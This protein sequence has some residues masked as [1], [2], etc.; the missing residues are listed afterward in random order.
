MAPD[1]GSADAMPIP[2][3]CYPAS[4]R[5]PALNTFPGSS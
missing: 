1:P 4:E 5:T 2:P 3:G